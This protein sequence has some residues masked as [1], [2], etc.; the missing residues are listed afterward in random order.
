[1]GM[2]LESFLD[3]SISTW[4]LAK[5]KVFMITLIPYRFLVRCVPSVLAGH[6][7]NIY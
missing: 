6:H 2:S 5:V 3:F 1:M 4:L 7:L